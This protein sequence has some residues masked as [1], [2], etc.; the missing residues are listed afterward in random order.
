MRTGP[1]LYKKRGTRIAAS[2]VLAAGLTLACQSVAFANPTSE[3]SAPEGATTLWIDVENSE[4]EAASIV[5]HLVS[6]GEV[7]GDAVT[8]SQSPQGLTALVSD[9]PK[10][11]ELKLSS[12]DA[13]QA[14]VSLTFANASGDFIA[15]TSSEITITPESVEPSTVPS[16]PPLTSAP[17]V[18][19]E[20]S[21]TSP[22]DRKSVV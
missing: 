8:F 21:P 19:T 20:A 7:P 17:P 15:G 22:P 1:N 18:P 16:L 5:A 3:V 9:I 11:F 2:I 6:S 4:L 13:A 14:R 12:R 10:S